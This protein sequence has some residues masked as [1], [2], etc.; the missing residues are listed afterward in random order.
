MASTVSPL[1]RELSSVVS[2]LL[3]PEPILFRAA[4]ETGVRAVRRAC[5]SLSEGTTHLRNELNR[6]AFL[7][8]CLDFTEGEAVEH[9]IVG[10]G[11]KASTT[12]RVRRVLHS[13]GSA[14]AVALPAS[15]K[16]DIVGFVRSETRAS[17]VIFHNHPP[18]PFRRL[19]DNSPLASDMDRQLMS[20]FQ[21]LSLRLGRHD[22]F[23]FYIGENGFVREFNTPQLLDVGD[24][25]TQRPR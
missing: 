22:I 19:L 10:L 13:V 24:A 8:G 18:H 17:V 11:R 15:F 6:N 16:N 5:K 23:R 7:C 20:A 14:R 21:L 4:D 25:L 2:S 1:I 3:D 9:L 12:T